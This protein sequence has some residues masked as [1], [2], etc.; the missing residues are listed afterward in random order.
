MLKNDSPF[1]KSELAK[2]LQVCEE[3]ADFL[4]FGLHGS[5]FFIA[6]FKTLVKPE[7]IHHDV[8]ACFKAEI[9]STLEQIKGKLPIEDVSI[10][11]DITDIQNK[12]MTGNLIFFKKEGYP[13][14][15]AVPVPSV[16]KRQVATPE[17]EYTVTGPKEAFVE[18]LD[19]NLN[20]VRKRLPIP[21]LQV[22][23]LK[24]G[25]L[26]KTRVAVVYVKGIADQENVNTVIQR[27]QGI[28]YDEI[29]DTSFLSQMIA[30]NKNSPFPQ[31]IDTERPDRLAAVL[32]EGKIGI[33]SDGSPTA[34]SGPVS[35]ITYFAA[36][37]DYLSIWNVASAFRLLRIFAVLFSILA[38]PSYVAI[39]TFHY[40]MIPRDVLSLLITSRGTIPF[41][42]FLEAVLLELA[43]ELLREAGARL[44]TKIGQTI[45]IVGG[46]VLGTAAVQ[47]GLTSNVLLIVVATGALASFTTPIYQVSSVIRLIRFPFI[48][49]AHLLGLVGVAVCFAFLISHLLKLTSLGRPFL[50][51]IYPLR[52]E[53]LKDSVI[54]LPFD[55]QALRPLQIRAQDRLR[56]QQE[57]SPKKDWDIDD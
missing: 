29:A 17:T 50:E 15:L 23:E 6:Y 16:E 5:P 12:L 26:S 14:C 44:P 30:D 46:I 43:I 54:R 27:I 35:L 31:L 57:A 25:K 49:F 55:K 8:L 42:P 52:V 34:I 28:E 33:F 7:I 3:S 32:A 11:D 40:E 21:E 39:L 41:P 53:D 48:L 2:L 38:T 18:S 51:P 47:A 36:F 4:S 1:Q 22:K 19:T 45:G 20:L 9:P 10:T 24:I 13:V 37:E 56:F